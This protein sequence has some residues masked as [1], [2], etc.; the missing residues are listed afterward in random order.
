MTKKHKNDQSPSPMLLT[1]AQLAEQL[2]VN[3]RTVRRLI[4]KAEI[5][6]IRI[7]RLVR[8][9][10]QDRDDFLRRRRGP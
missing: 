5:R 6:A 9:S 3:E 7:G 2:Q 10:A 1:V 4:D 8:I